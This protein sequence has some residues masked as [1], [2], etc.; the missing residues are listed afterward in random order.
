MNFIDILGAHG[1]ISHE[2]FTTCLRVSNDIVID[3]GNIIR[4]LGEDAYKINH[5]FIS[6]AHLD[7]IIDIAFLIDN[8]FLLRH[9]PLK[10][11]ATSKT[12]E[13]F[14]TNIF[15]WDIWPDFSTLQLPNINKNSLEFIE[16]EFDKEY[17]FDNGFS[18]TPIEANHTV[19]CSGYLCKKDGNGILFS[20][21][22]YKNPKIWERLNSDKSIKALII[23]V[24]FPNRFAD[25]SEISKH[26]SPLHLEEELKLLRR[27]NCEIYIYHIK[28]I[29]QDELT[30]ELIDIGIEKSHILKGY[31]KISYHDGSLLEKQNNNIND[32]IK[33][34][35]KIGI[36]LSSQHDLPLLLEMIIQESMKLT[37][38]DGGTLYLRDGEQLKFHIA[39]TISLSK[40]MGG[41]H[42]PISWKPLQIYLENGEENRG[43]VAV[44]SL[45]DDRIINIEDIYSDSEFMFEGS[46]KFDAANNYQS[47]SS[48]TIPIKNHENEVI[49]VLQLLNK[50]DEGN[51]PIAFNRIDEDII[52]SLA[53]Q[54]GVAINNAQ[55][56]KDIEKMLE[57][58]LQSI[59]YAMSEKSP[60]TASHIHKMVAFTNMLVDAID[61]DETLFKDK[62]FS[63]LQKQVINISALMHDVGKIATPDI[64][65]EKARKL[66]T[67]VDRI[68]MIKDRFELIKKD[69]E[70]E[71]LKLQLSGKEVEKTLLDSAVAKLSNDF[72]KLAQCN[73]GSEFLAQ[74]KVDFIQNLVKSPLKVFE[75][76]YSLLTQEEANLLCIQRG[77]LSDADRKAINYH[78]TVTVNML[79]KL[80]LPK[81]Y[82]DIPQI[83]GNHHEKINGK[84]YPKG[85]KGDEISFEAR[86]LA[87]ADVFEAITAKDRPYKKPN[88]ITT[89]MNIIHKMTDEGDLDPQI[90]EFLES[91]KL[92]LEYAK[93]YEIEI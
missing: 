30:H 89:S 25:I 52:S 68:D 21:D 5:I 53:S 51:N 65:M 67:I 18:I 15:N 9:K 66:E 74:E 3:G 41:S 14:K 16:I 38:C 90:V 7:H 33:R 22:T 61:K 86:I 70:I 58:F 44:T 83:S 17:T 82:K 63:E 75:N 78:A 29:Y 60:H 35:N 32:K 2:A 80:Y 87:V 42:D 84:G 79:N 34:L 1:S 27:N 36:A 20:G 57:S 64:V 11:Y 59:V 6:H 62:H 69:L 92:Y 72:E 8:T 91:S 37:N 43:M 71:Y 12:I 45:L 88:S 55:F 28:P 47:K 76:E 56:I 40:Y 77:T 48:L 49:G 54:A 50:L 19:E 26:M 39:Q 13:S 81:K 23:D 31:E 24:S 93:K 73:M 85:L 10:I 46:K 4:G